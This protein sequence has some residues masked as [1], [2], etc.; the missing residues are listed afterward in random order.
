MPSSGQT[1]RSSPQQLLVLFKFDRLALIF[2]GWLAFMFY[3]PTLSHGFVWDDRTFLLDTP[4][5]RDPEMWLQQL[6]QPLFVSQ[7]YFRPLPMLSFI[8]E[9]R[10]GELNASVFHLT[11]IILHAINTSLLVWLARRLLPGSGRLAAVA[12]LIYG[13]HP[14]LVENVAWISDRFDLMMVLFVL[15]TL[16]SVSS[17]ASIRRRSVGVAVLSLCA[18]LS[19]ESAVVLLVILP[20]WW[21]LITDSTRSARQFA[22]AAWKSDFLPLGAG[23]LLGMAAYLLLRLSVL[24][25]YYQNDSIM[26]AG[27][28]LQHV[29]LVAKTIG[30][31]VGLAVWPFGQMNPTHPAVTPC[32]A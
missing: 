30:W 12:G 3:L 17:D 31:Y 32:R 6:A 27:S 19:K 5:L 9:A 26:S 2:P 28:A 21:I 1:G 18:L 11:N 25:H 14:A 4:Y 29:L 20:L 16:V 24:S 8:I 10:L 7:N 22:E 15:L 13:L 23:L